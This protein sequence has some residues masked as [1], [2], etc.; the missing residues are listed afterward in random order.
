MGADG[1]DPNGNR[2]AGSAYV[3]RRESNGDITEITKLTA[4]DG[5]AYDDFGSAVA[6]D[7]N[8]IAIGAYSADVERDGSLQG[9]AGKVYLYKMVDGNA[10][11]MET[12]TFEYPHYAYFGSSLAIS[13][14]VLAVGS[15][16]NS[17][18]PDGSY[19]G[20]DYS[21][22]VSLSNYRKTAQPV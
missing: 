16:N 7:G 1:D 8:F 11:Y 18:N 19:T 22:S 10:S 20:N 4:P 5:R 3:F 13:D 17:F 9:Y 6:V 2:E 15:K 21:G 14:G 12:L